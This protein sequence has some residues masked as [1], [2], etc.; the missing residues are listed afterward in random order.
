MP[1]TRP[2]YRPIPRTIL[3]RRGRGRY[4]RQTYVSMYVRYMTYNGE[5]K[6]ARWSIN[7]TRLNRKQQARVVRWICNNIKDRKIPVC[8]KGMRFRSLGEF[9]SVPW[10]RVRKVLSY[11]PNVIYRRV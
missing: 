10:I 1:E 7:L 6:Y 3:A 5:E 11:E 9:L 2:R 4:Q 8:P